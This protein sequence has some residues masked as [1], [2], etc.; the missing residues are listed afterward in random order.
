MAPS[1]VMGRY[2]E[3]VLDRLVAKMMKMIDLAMPRD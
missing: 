3:A 1:W 2:Q